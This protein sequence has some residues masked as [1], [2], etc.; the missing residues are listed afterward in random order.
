MRTAQELLTIARVLLRA[1]EL[2]LSRRVGEDKVVVAPIAGQMDDCLG[3]LG[4]L[5]Q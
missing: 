3:V 4:S 2:F 5:T 1:L